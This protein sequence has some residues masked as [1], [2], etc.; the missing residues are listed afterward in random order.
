MYEIGKPLKVE[1]VI[2]DPPGEEQVRL[3]MVSAGLCGSDAHH[4]LGEQELPSQFLPMVMGHEGA[5]FVES[6]GPNVTSVQPGDYVLTTFMPQCGK[7]TVCL[8][9][10]TNLCEKENGMA[11]MSKSNKKLSKDGS[12]IFGYCGLGTYSEFVLVRFS[13][14]VK[15]SKTWCQ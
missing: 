15:V 8:N 7:C 9:P 13:Q 6:V 2:I 5:A 12:E 10:R 4:V 1:D 14:I 3:R 11:F